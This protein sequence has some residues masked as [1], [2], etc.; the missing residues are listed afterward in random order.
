M[1]LNAER[2]KC[3][4]IPI[5]STIINNQST[6]ARNQSITVNLLSTTVKYLSINRQSTIIDPN[7]LNQQSSIINPNPFPRKF[8]SLKHYT[9]KLLTDY[10]VIYTIYPQNNWGGQLNLLHIFQWLNNFDNYIRKRFDNNYLPTLKRTFLFVK[11]I[12]GKKKPP[13][14]NF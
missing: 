1:S 11:Y 8:N 12:I 14:E 3:R 5:K 2:T 13:T 7:S 6:T 4:N 10:T 9:G